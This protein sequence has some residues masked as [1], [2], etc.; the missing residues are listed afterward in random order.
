MALL[1]SCGSSPPPKAELVDALR[2]SGI[3]AT[4]AR[5]AVDAIY[6]TLS[7]EQVAQLVERGAGG[8]PKEDPDRTDDPTDRLTRAIARCREDATTEP[9]TGPGEA[10]TTS[11][12]ADSTTTAGASSTTG[13]TLDTLDDGGSPT[14]SPPN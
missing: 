12:P 8:V 5:C 9:I 11:A 4:Q 3:P 7:D 1:G 6:A 2:T 10:T 14:T 13:A